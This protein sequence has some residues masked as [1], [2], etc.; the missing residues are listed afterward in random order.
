MKKVFLLFSIFILINDLKAQ[1]CTA[2]LVFTTQASIDNFINT[3]QGCSAVNG[4]VKI[5]GNDITNLDGLAVLTVIEGS[6]SIESTLIKN[7]N[8]LSGITRIG[9][10]IDINN[11]ASLTSLAGLSALADIGSSLRIADNSVLTDITSLSKIEVVNGFLSVG[12]NASLASL[13]GLENIQSVHGA[14]AIGSDNA[15]TNL[16]GL[17]KLTSI[18]GYIFIANN[19]SLLNLTGLINVTSISGYI[20]ISHNNLLTSLAGIDNIDPSGIEYVTL[21]DSQALSFCGVKSMCLSISRSARTNI[22]ANAVGC[23]SSEEI[24]SSASCLEILPVN[25]ISFTGKN[26][27]EGNLLSWQ[28][29]SETNNAGFSVEQ[30][31][32]GKFFEAIG[33]VEG[34]N[35]VDNQT[36]NYSFIDRT[37]AEISYYRLKQIDFDQTFAYSKII[38]VKTSGLITGTQKDSIFIFPNP[39]QGSLIIEAKNRNQEY[40]IMTLQGVTLKEESVLPSK[41][42]DTNFLQNGLYMISVGKEVFKVMV[43]N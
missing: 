2:D 37:P 10:A 39:A 12:R 24:S 32:N 11:N 9:G 28:T 35:N 4:S 27:I 42:I 6:L 25:L 29:T 15:L 33:F 40:R 19:P 34:S 41:P 7:L 23:A 1:V 38:V 22:Y 13:A 21:V 17:S 43:T 16:N 5:V 30:S 36:R 3:N 20:N 8:G 26:T 14:L 31:V 18:L